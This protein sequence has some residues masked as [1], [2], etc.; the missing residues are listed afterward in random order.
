M[1]YETWEQLDDV[2]EVQFK[3]DDRRAFHAALPG[4]L[5]SERG[6]GVWRPVRADLAAPAP[7][8]DQPSA[9][10]L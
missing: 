7:D 4:L 2:V 3:R 1:R 9:R 6:I 10:L 5:R 8:A